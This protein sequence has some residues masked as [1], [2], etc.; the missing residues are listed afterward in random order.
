MIETQK[1]PKLSSFYLKVKVALFKAFKKRLVFVVEV[2]VLSE[3][4]LLFGDWLN[5][6]VSVMVKLIC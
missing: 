5:R 4:E 3:Q 2:L 6:N 1:K